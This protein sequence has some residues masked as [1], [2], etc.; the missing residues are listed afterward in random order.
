ML[1]KSI[2]ERIFKRNELIVVV[3]NFICIL[4]LCFCML[5]SLCEV[6]YGCW[7]FKAFNRCCVGGNC[8]RKYSC[9]KRC[10]AFDSSSVD[11]CRYNRYAIPW[12]MII[13]CF[14]V[15][16]Y[17]CISFVYFSRITTR[18][19]KKHHTFPLPPWLLF[20]NS[21]FDF[22][23]LSSLVSSDLLDSIFILSLGI[24]FIITLLFSLICSS[25]FRFYCFR[26]F[27]FWI[28]Y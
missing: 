22:L 23:L 1:S 14:L 19:K 27:H 25:S 12:G 17:I 15:Y 4:W 28:V 6:E 8:T 3:L 5:C 9:E 20:F 18:V 7:W 16:T 2:P 26:V 10:R 13:I 11:G 21:T 24:R